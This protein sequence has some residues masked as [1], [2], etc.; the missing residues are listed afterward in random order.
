M[1]P[2]ADT[3]VVYAGDGETTVFPFTF[4]Y[5]EA[6]DI[7]VSLYEIA[8]DT[9]TVLTKDYYVDTTA[10][11]VTYPGYP[12]GQEAAESERPAPLDSAHRIVIYRET[13]ISQPVDLGSKYPLNTLEGMHDRAIMLIQEIS[14]ITARTVTVEAGSDEQPNEVIKDVR[15]KAELAA[16]SASAAALSEAAA[17]LSEANAKASETAAA[18]SEANA[19][20]SENAAALSESNAKSSETMAAESATAAAL[21]ESAAA[22]SEANAKES[23]TESAK[24]ATAAAESESQA[25]GY[26]KQAEDKYTEIKEYTKDV[27]TSK[28]EAMSYAALIMGQTASAWSASKAYNVDDVVIYTDGYIYRCIGYSAPGTIPLGSDLWVQLKVALRDDFFEL[29]SDG[30]LVQTEEPTFS[31]IFMLN[32]DDYIT[33]KE[34]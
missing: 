27:E 7:K 6:T 5:A 19:K 15:K 13:E 31:S 12:P 20:E 29:T 3:K 26:A 33:I 14:E 4:K 1:I 24:S 18:L 22:A 28:N 10:G 11:T 9:T 30:Y 25:N 8:T 32:G 2:Y 17:A 23:E 34:A 21:S 16:N